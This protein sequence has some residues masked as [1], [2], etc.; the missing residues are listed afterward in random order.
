[1]CSTNPRQANLTRPRWDDVHQADDLRIATYAGRYAF[2]PFRN[3]F[4]SFPVNPTLR[5]QESGASWVAGQWK[6]DVESD[7]RGVGRP[8]TRW[9]ADQLLYDP[10]TNKI[11]QNST[12]DAPDENFPMN[13]NRLTNP[14]CTLRTTGWN[15]WQPLFHNPQATFETPFDHF[16]PSR[17][18]DKYRCRT[19]PVPMKTYTQELID[20]ERQNKAR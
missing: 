7:L 13:F 14:P 10:R 16:I 2:T 15:R 11:N 18:I 3:C 5:I 12:Q 9:R 8:P 6:T 20:E 19:H 17:D 4:E 1:M